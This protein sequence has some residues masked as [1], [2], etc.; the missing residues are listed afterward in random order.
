MPQVPNVLL[1]QI[2]FSMAIVKRV[3]PDAPE[4][5][6]IELG[7]P[8]GVGLVGQIYL[9][10]QLPGNLIMPMRLEAGEKQNELRPLTT[11]WFADACSE[12]RTALLD[13]LCRAKGV[14]RKGSQSSE[15][16]PVPSDL[17]PTPE[18]L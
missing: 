1:P 18:I 4:G 2:Q 3:L 16:T 6:Q 7:Q 10:V 15:A 14:E 13:V 8:P 9:C 5:Q 11:R 17:P 12:C